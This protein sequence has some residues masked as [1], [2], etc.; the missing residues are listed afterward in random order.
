MMHIGV[1]CNFRQQKHTFLAK[2][3]LLLNNHDFSLRFMA[4]SYPTVD[5]IQNTESSFFLSKNAAL[6][7]IRSQ[8][9]PSLFLIR[10]KPDISAS[11]LNFS[12]PSRVTNSSDDCAS[13]RISFN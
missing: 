5:V 7:S 9:V 8:T 11:T 10:L 12:L 2:F 6:S 4:D 13:A 3:L 1:L